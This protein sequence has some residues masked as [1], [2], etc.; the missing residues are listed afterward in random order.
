MDADEHAVEA[1]RHD[2]GRALVKEDFLLGYSMGGRL[3]LQWATAADMLPRGLILVGAHPGI[4]TGP[5]KETRRRWDHEQ[6]SALEAIGARRHML[7]WQDQP[8][9]ATQ[10][11]RMEPRAHQHMVNRRQESHSR[12]LAA[13]LRGFGS[14]T[15]PDCW[16]L[17]E[18]ITC[19]VLLVTGAQDE[20]YTDLAAEMC[21]KLPTGDLLTVPDAGHAAHLENPAAFLD[22]LQHWMGGR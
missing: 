20:R 19:P 10:R 7:Q 14:G 2:L 22:G 21:A 16:D 8:L 18:G 1:Q 3:A 11:E 13:S 4:P 6:A 9:I 17:L 5:E 12:S 15:M